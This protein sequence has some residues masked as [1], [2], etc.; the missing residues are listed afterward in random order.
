M[1]DTE[2][3]S[4]MEMDAPELLDMDAVDDELGQPEPE[5]TDAS[6][7]ERESGDEE[8]ATSF[9]DERVVDEPRNIT[10][11]RYVVPDEERRTSHI[12]SI[13]EYTEAISLRTEQ[14]SAS[15][16]SGCMLDATKN[17]IPPNAD[18]ARDLAL[19]E[20]RARKCPLKLIRVV[21]SMVGADSKTYSVVEIWKVNTM[22]HPVFR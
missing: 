14:I 17:E 4:E 10:A 16:L 3:E 18:T 11:A 22:T 12:M 1:V 7:E 9:F 8:G 5:E 19:A 20:M 21:G 2:S 6:D 13:A 15:G